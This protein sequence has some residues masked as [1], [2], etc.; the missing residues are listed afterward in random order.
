VRECQSTPVEW[1]SST[2][3][4]DLDRVSGH[5]AYRCASFIDLYLHTKFHINQQ[6]LFGRTN[7]RDPLQVQGHV[8]Q[9]VGKIS[10]IRPEQI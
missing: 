7:R 10:K 5:R 3:D 8:T 2:H 6:K 1:L 4:L 9:K